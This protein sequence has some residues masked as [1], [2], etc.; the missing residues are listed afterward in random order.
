MQK[1]SYRI[2]KVQVFFG[3]KA[4]TTAFNSQ[5]C[6]ST[7]HTYQQK[8][9]TSQMLMVFII[10]KEHWRCFN[11]Y[12]HKSFRTMLGNML[13]RQKKTVLLPFKQFLSLSKTYT[14]KAEE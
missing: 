11:L 13:I 4:F 7:Q 5:L 8:H 2:G 9:N 3:H 12:Q 6:K 14:K 10:F 1:L